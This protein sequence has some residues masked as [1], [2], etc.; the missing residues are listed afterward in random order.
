MARK[1]I[2]RTQKSTAR[3][4]RSKKRA[5]PKRRAAAK[6][7][8]PRKAAAAKKA[9]P[10]KAAAAK[11]AA[12]RKAAA[13]KKA[14]PRKAAARKAVARKAAPK[15]ARSVRDP[16]ETFEADLDDL[17][18]L[19]E[20]HETLLP[21]AEKDDLAEELGEEYVE[22]ATS[23]EQSSEDTRDAELPEESGGPFVQTSAATEFAYDTDASNPKDAKRAP[24][25][26][27]GREQ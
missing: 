1:K 13:A 20:E 2:R 9:A 26:T 15:K 3:A 19:R 7:A 10:R 27:T 17:Q 24:F 5:A 23:G 6:K 16:D 18:P 4:A 8:A 25:P 11:K 21:G 12:P 14:A 22:A